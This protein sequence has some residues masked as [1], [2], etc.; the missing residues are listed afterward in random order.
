MNISLPENLR[1]WVEAQVAQGGYATA[2]EY[3]RQ[4]LREEQKRQLRAE[5]DTKLL[6]ALDSGEPLSANAEFWKELRREARARLAER[7]AE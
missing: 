1:A 6:A 5:I 7:Q 4:L 2:S 3:L